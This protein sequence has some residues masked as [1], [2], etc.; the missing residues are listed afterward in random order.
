[1]TSSVHDSLQRTLG[2]SGCARL[3]ERLRK[4]LEAELELTGRLNLS[5]PT[6]RERTEIEGLLG[7]R[8]GQGTGLNISLDELGGQ[9][10]RA[11]LADSLEAAVLALTGP[12]E[13][14]RA[15]RAREE[16][17]WEE[18]FATFAKPESDLPFDFLAALREQGLLK[19]IGKPGTARNYLTQL[20]RLAG[21]L[22]ADGEPLPQLAARLFGDSHTLDPGQ[23]LANLALRLIP[24]IAAIEEDPDATRA[25]ARR[26]AWA[27]VRVIC[28]DLSAPPIVLNLPAKSD[29]LL[30]QL[31]RLAH[32]AGEPVHLSLRQIVK[33]P[34]LHDTGFL[35]RTIYV[36]ENPT[37]LAL[38]ANTHGPSCAPLIC[39]NGE[40]AT[41]ARTLLRQLRDAGAR[42]RYH[43]DFDWRG[44]AIAARVLRFC[45]ANPWRFD[46]SSYGAAPKHH[47]LRGKPI[48]TPWDPSLSATMET[49]GKSVHEEAIANTLLDDLRG[50]TQAKP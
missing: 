29:H 24:H 4:R 33:Y 21:S 41:P 5:N 42:L 11:G 3:L 45:N 20:E 12:L 16:A 18:L 6:P 13:N 37:I 34:L 40:P 47:P 26:N 35:D 43:G 46:A 2:S 36:C 28:D 50:P 15:A 23:P 38:A 19:R 30:G 22:P 8:P 1:M 31:L 9:I 48:A 49:I 17:R 25:D 7:R 32:N 44:V 27:S 14:K 39:I 10:R